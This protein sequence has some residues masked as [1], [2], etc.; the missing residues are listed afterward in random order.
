M[1]VCVSN[2]KMGYK[3]Y[4]GKL[5]PFVIPIYICLF[6]L[7]RGREKTMRNRISF[8]SFCAFIRTDSEFLPSFQGIQTWLSEVN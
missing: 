5:D 8:A 6:I 4:I 1:N 3:Q 2:G 7:I